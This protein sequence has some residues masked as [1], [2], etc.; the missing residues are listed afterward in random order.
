[1]AVIPSPGDEYQQYKDRADR[2]NALAELLYRTWN[3]LNIKSIWREPEPPR[4]TDPEGP[5]HGKW[6][7]ETVD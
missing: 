5:T 7:C 6:I 3:N 4:P 1:M 2:N